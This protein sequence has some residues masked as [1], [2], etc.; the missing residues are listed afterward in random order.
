MVSSSGKWFDPENIAQPRLIF[1]SRCEMRS[2]ADAANNA[3]DV[4]ILSEY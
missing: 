1:R 2:E 3:K 4:M